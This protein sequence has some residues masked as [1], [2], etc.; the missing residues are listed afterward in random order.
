[1]PTFTDT[2]TTLGNAGA[3]D[4]LVAHELTT[5]ADS[6]LTSVGQQA[7]QYQ[8]GL[9][10]IYLPNVASIGLMAFN[11]CTGLKTIYVGTGRNTMTTL[12]NNAFDG[13]GRCIIRVPD[14]LV[15]TYRSGANWNTYSMLIYGETDATAPTWDETEIADDM[16]TFKSHVNAGTAASRYNIGQYKTIDLG[17][18]GSGRAQIVAKNVR[19][20]ANSIDTAQLEFVT[21]FA[22]EPQIRMNPA[23]TAN[24][25]GTGSIGG[26]DASE[27]KAYIE[28]TIWPLFPSDWQDIIKECKIT[29][30]GY[31][32]SETS[33]T[34]M[35]STAKVSL[36]SYREV[37]GGTTKETIG[38]VYD[39]AFFNSSARIRGISNTSS[40]RWWLRSATGKS[41]FVTVSSGN[42]NMSNTADQIWFMVLRFSV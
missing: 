21:S 6:D 31:D 34:D 30:Y 5:F 38:P 19:E 41:G 8:T 40:V 15:A 1:M 22:L 35:Q 16:A 24:T 39:F 37:F 7:F 12:G 3:L 14:S 29:S 23:Y 18:A 17:T 27:M 13:C 4:A 2:K 42:A 32:T 36:L 10:T 9:E 25:S 28:N 33:V 11:Q 20:L 26:Y